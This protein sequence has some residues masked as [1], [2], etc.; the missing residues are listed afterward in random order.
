M[1]NTE[2]IAGLVWCYFLE[3][4]GLAPSDKVSFLIK[5]QTHGMIKCI[6]VDLKIKTK[7]KTKTYKA[8]EGWYVPENTENHFRFLEYARD[9]L[10]ELER[11][12]GFNNPLLSSSDHCFVLANEIQQDAGE[13][14][15]NQEWC[16]SA[17][18]R[19]QRELLIANVKSLPPEVKL[20]SSRT[21]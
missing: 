15:Q 2:E 14:L 10:I 1:N 18:L 19:A 16:N 9:A 17:I 7:T 4:L 20:V 8:N 5:N 6:K 21:L 12:S 11:K 3:E 13:K